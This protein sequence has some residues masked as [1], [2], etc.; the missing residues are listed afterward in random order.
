MICITCPANFTLFSSLISPHLLC[1]WL[2]YMQVLAGTR[3]ATKIAAAPE[4]FCASRKHR[5]SMYSSSSSSSI[6]L[7]L[8]SSPCPL[9]PSSSILTIEHRAGDR[10]VEVKDYAPVVFTLIRRFFGVSIPSY[11]VR[12]LPAFSRFFSVL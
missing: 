4:D 1:T 10:K 6:L 11:L 12:P 5:I 8:L 2:T 7:P 9:P 3:D